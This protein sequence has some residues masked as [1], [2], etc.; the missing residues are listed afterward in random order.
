M[1][2]KSQNTIY[3]NKFYYIFSIVIKFQFPIYSRKCFVWLKFDNRCPKKCI[4]YKLYNIMS[5][6]SACYLISDNF[7]YWNLDREKKIAPRSF[8]TFTLR[9]VE[10]EF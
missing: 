7:L 8:F 10:S 3:F 6:M 1:Q 4:V 5:I 9:R 2:Y